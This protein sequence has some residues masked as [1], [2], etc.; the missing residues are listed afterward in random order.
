MV[1]GM[2]VD[3]MHLNHLF[4]KMFDLTPNMAVIHY[5]KTFTEFDNWTL[6]EMEV[7]I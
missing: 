2:G 6:Q 5:M 3:D 4:I 1:S 7:D